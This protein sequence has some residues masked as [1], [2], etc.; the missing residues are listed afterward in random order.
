MEDSDNL[1]WVID[2][3]AFIEIENKI[4]TRDKYFQLPVISRQKIQEAL[5]VGKAQYR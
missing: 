4:Q 3:L 2:I 1:A 5:L